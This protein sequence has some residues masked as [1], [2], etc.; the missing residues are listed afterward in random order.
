M[1]EG[2]TVIVEVPSKQWTLLIGLDKETYKYSV[3]VNGLEMS[4]L[5]KAPNTVES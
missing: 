3:G 4:E 1:E 5:P 2:E